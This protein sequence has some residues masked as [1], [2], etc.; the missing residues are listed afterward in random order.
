MYLTF[1]KK[2]YAK[3]IL[4]IQ[5][6]AKIYFR[7][8]DIYVRYIFSHVGNNNIARSGTVGIVVQWQIRRLGFESR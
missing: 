4:I 2:I 3:Y 8:F 7:Y 1:I 6:F 5:L